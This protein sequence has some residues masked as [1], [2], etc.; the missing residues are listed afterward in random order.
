MS[1]TSHIALALASAVALGSGA[2]RPTLTPLFMTTARG[3]FDVKVIPQ[4]AGD[5]AGGPWGHFV[6]D[7]KYHGGLE[8]TAKGLMLASGDPSSGNAALVAFEQV[9]GTLAGRHGIFVLVHKGTIANG[10]TNYHVSVVP[11]SGTGELAGLSGELTIINDKGK[12]SYV[13][14]YSLPGK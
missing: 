6:L 14:E 5:S 7:K 4:P 12:H 1:H 13:L 2:A 9:S 11:G 10:E 3:A 8:G